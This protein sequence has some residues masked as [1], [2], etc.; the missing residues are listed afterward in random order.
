MA[1]NFQRV[2]KQLT[3]S[4]EI[5]KQIEK[6]IL[7][8]KFIPGQKLPTEL[9]LCETFGVSR[10]ALREALQMLSARGLISVKKGSGIYV[11]KYSTANAIRQMR[12]YLELNLD[13]DYLQHIVQVRNLLEPN[14]AR[15]SVKN[16]TESD[17]QYMEEKIIALENCP[18]HDFKIEGGLDRDFHLAIAHSSGN[19]MIPLII[20][21]IYQ[22]MPKIKELILAEIDDVKKLTVVSHRLIYDKI[23]VQDEEGAFEAMTEHLKTAEEHANLI[24]EKL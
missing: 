20:T 1:L 8:K 2:G 10:T 14:F 24:A 15:L 12:L 9:E 19:P 13:R 3:F 23:L 6:A 18:P 17:L 22:I 21:P 7:S 16:R 4:Q 5:E 11:E